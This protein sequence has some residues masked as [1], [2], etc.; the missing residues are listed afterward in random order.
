VDFDKSEATIEQGVRKI[1]LPK[2]TAGQTRT[3]PVRPG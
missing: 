2:R 3:I 1:R